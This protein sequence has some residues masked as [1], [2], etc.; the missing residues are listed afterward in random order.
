[1]KTT[2]AAVALAVGATSAVAAP[3]AGAQEAPTG[4]VQYA[5]TT[6]DGNS[7]ASGSLENELVQ[8]G[9]VL[10]AGL[11]VAAGLAIA[12]GVRGGAFPLPEIP[13]LPR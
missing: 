3:S 1:M 10:V 7:S 6:A 8:S 11:A 2:A 4:V 5:T 13:G 12:A 9:L